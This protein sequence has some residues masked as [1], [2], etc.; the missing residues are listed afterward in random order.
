MSS[1]PRLEGLVQIGFFVA[2]LSSI[3]YV[4]VKMQSDVMVVYKSINILMC[5]QLQCLVLVIVSIYCT[6]KHVFTLELLFTAYIVM[7]V[8]LGED[9]L[10]KDFIIC[11]S[12]SVA[13][14]LIGLRD[15]AVIATVNN[16][17]CGMIPC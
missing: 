14:F 4:C 6:Y 13:M 8:C 15:N 17:K 9:R 3:I 16:Y 10:R 12:K 1:K 7:Y 11:L 5:I 2:I